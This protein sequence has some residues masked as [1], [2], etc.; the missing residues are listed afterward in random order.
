MNTDLH[1]GLC[2]DVGRPE[3]HSAAG[4]ETLQ[5]DEV[6]PYSSEQQISKYRK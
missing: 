6:R 1:A 5:H 2:A 4:E 3:R